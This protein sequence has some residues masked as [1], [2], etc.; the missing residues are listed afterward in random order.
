VSAIRS[1]PYAEEGFFTTSRLNCAATLCL[2]V[3][4]SILLGYNL[5]G[6]S[7]QMKNATLLFAAQLLLA[8]GIS[9][10]TPTFL[11]G[12]VSIFN[13]LF[14]S[15]F[16]A[17]GRL[18][19]LNLRKNL[20]RNAVAVAAVF[21]GIT[22][23]VSTSGFVNSVKE[24]AISWLDSVVRADIIV[25][26]GHPS[27]STNAQTIPMPIEMMRDMEKTPGVLA[28]DPWRKIYINYQGR[29]VL[30]STIDIARRSAYCHFEIVQAVADNSLKLLPNQDKVLVSEP[31][32]AIFGVKPGDTLELPTPLGPVRFGI[33][34]VLVDYLCDN[35]T[36]V[37]DNNTYQ[38]HW[39]DMLAN[40]FNVR[41]KPG[42]N[43]SEVRNAIQKRFG[44]DRLLFVLPVWEFKNEIRKVLDRT[45]IFN[46][47]LNVITLTIA[48]LGIIVTLFASILE[49]TR[50]I[51]ILR[52]IGMLRSQISGVVVLESMLMGLAGGFLGSITGILAGWINLEGFFV[53]SYGSA[54]KYYVPYVA[55]IWALVLSGGLSALAGLIPAAKAAKTNIVEALAYD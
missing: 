29:N 36:I 40:S 14:S 20:T 23:F 47:A 39:G 30:L 51:G 41:V 13:R 3:S 16:G 54:A 6:N 22:V 53:A 26:S 33:A 46:Y 32:A 25:T 52:S 50:E 15:S 49:R 2:C 34:G 8:V 19:G 9:L 18:A 4:F 31:F 1:V 10:F 48:C 42:H 21:F 55:I 37:M 45:F 27:S 24:S 38:R 43:I 44:N 5:L 7:S 35:G 11:R 28:V 12:F 17:A